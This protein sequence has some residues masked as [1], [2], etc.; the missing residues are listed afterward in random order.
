MKKPKMI[1][2]D[3]GGTLMTPIHEFRGI[4]GIR[5]VLK[6]AK[7]TH[8]V[9]AEEIQELA[10]QLQKD[11]GRAFDYNAP[12]LTTEVHQ[13]PFDRYLYE[14]FNLE[15]ELTPYELEKIF[16]DT[17]D[18]GVAIPYINEL[19]SYLDEAGIRTGVISNISF[20]SRLLCDRIR[21]AIP[22]HG[23]EFIVTSSDYVFCK[24]HPR[25]FELG[26]RKAQLSADQVWYCGDNVRCD[27][28]GAHNSGIYPVWY[29]GAVFGIQEA[30]DVEHLHIKDWRELIAFLRNETDS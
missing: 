19:L 24:P 6:H 5:E 13:Y 20:S 25:I 23:F 14:Y 3:F 9:T 29:T 11:L 27:V 26:L 30:P 17:A 28:V 12:M 16:W 18:P 21:S 1:M 15:L 7:D 4:E 22:N 2:F 8:G 10:D